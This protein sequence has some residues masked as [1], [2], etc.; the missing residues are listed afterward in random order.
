M[1]ERGKIISTLW[2]VPMINAYFCIIVSTVSQKSGGIIIMLPL[3]IQNHTQHSKERDRKSTFNATG[4]LI[5]IHNEKLKDP[6]QLACV[7]NFL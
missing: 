2:D 3:I 7:L 6:R 5:L 1:K 4:T